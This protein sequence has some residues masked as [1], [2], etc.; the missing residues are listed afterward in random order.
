[1][2]AVSVTRPYRDRVSQKRDDLQIKAIYVYPGDGFAWVRTGS[3]SAVPSIF[4]V[5]MHLA[6]P[7]LVV[8]MKV[9][10]RP[11][12]RALIRDF[13][14]S[15]KDL[16]S[17]V[18]T[19]L[20]R[21]VPVDRLLRA[22]LDKVAMK[23]VGRPDIHPSAFQIETDPETQAWVGPE[24]VQGRGREVAPDRVARAAEIYQQALAA[25][26]RKPAEVV[27]EELHYSRATAA[28]DIRTARERGLLPP[29]GESAPAA[30][31]SKLSPPSSDTVSP[32]PI[33]QRF[34]E[35]DAWAPMDDVLDG[36]YGLPIAHPG[37]PSNAMPDPVPAPP[38]RA[39]TDPEAMPLNREELAEP[40]SGPPE[41]Q[42][43][44]GAVDGANAAGD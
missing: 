27:A 23:A 28:R 2:V 33:W 19:R 12:G 4:D 30:V 1:M 16:S 36:P 14:L 11:G 7:D 5:Q 42:R 24:P 13:G 18:T 35:P 9:V 37:I 25:G 34:G 15:P 8:V 26:S 41:N 39:V 3:D 6:S 43:E 17:T 29:V 40:N 20:L 32:N 31:A 44:S 10:V 22:A 21:T 38:H